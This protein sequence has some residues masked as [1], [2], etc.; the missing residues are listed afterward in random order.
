MK[1]IFI[2]LMG[3]VFLASCAAT[4]KKQSG[5]LGEYYDNLKPGITEGGAKLIWIKPGVDFTKYKKVMVDYVIFAFAED[6]E[7]KGIDADEMKKIADA[8]S[9][10]LVQALEKEFPVVSEPGPD[11]IRIRTAIID[12]KPSR[13]G[14]SAVSTV[15]PVGLAVSLFKKGTT[16]AWTGSGATAAQMMILDSSRNE[17]LAAG[18]D[19]R[20]A[21]FEDRFSKWGS[22]EEVFKF[23]GER[24]TRNLVG[25]V[26]KNP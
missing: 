9:L 22:V 25:L 4:P 13:P 6:S 7:Y 21:R 16:D 8:A 24:L 20:A 14:L 3:M 2:L 5:V 12:L 1:K 26:K 23:W 15:M 11:V 18:E 19:Q 10:A 17:V